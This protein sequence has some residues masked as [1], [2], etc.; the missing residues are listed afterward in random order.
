[1]GDRDFPP[2]R[3]DDRLHWSARQTIGSARAKGTCS[4]Q[5]RRDIAVGK[6]MMRETG[7]DDE[8]EVQKQSE[9]IETSAAEAEESLS[10][11]SSSSSA[12][13]KFKRF[14]KV[15]VLSLTFLT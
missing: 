4:V 9:D 2:L 15:A 13:E 8:N 11:S 12:S 10:S 6:C 1:M 14:M 5:W 7:I 3:P